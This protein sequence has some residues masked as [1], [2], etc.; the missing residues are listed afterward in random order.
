MKLKIPK[1]RLKKIE[2][3]PKPILE[4]KQPEGIKRKVQE[5]TQKGRDWLANLRKKT[6]EAPSE[7]LEEVATP[8]EGLVIKV[9]TSPG[10]DE[11]LESANKEASISPKNDIIK[12]NEKGKYI[13]T[14]ED[15]EVVYRDTREEH[16]FKFSHQDFE[17]SDPGL[18][19][20][21]EASRSSSEM[22][23]GCMDRNGTI[24]W[25][26]DDQWLPNHLWRELASKPV[27]ALFQYL[28]G[29]NE[30][31][32]QST[33]GGA[34]NAIISFFDRSRLEGYNLKVHDMPNS[35]VIRFG[36]LRYLGERN[37]WNGDD[38]KFIRDADIPKQE[39]YEHVRPED[40]KSKIKN[41]YEGVR[42]RGKYLAIRT[43]GR[44]VEPVGLSSASLFAPNHTELFDARVGD[45]DKGALIY[46][47]DESAAILN[48]SEDARTFV[49]PK[50]N[51]P[52]PRDDQK[53][54]EFGD[55]VIYYRNSVEPVSLDQLHEQATKPSGDPQ[56]YSEI[57]LD[58]DNPN[59]KMV[60]VV[61]PYDVQGWSK[62]AYQHGVPEFLEIPEFSYELQKNKYRVTSKLSNL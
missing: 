20:E 35:A 59:C 36:E 62:I 23:E 55:R 48:F 53:V 54:L 42:S 19:S 8:P 3:P 11:T 41:I 51:A 14:R 25:K 7:V 56:Y 1:F 50:D 27:T 60:A 58:P 28:P 17:A 33:D 44:A 21:L 37:G 32:I 30:L 26:R 24:S 18:T 9:M 22:I 47:I 16:T 10:V 49:F 34:V 12:N 29:G 46:E 39:G 15:F 38:S 43:V 61:N 52:S 13:V 45:F 2:A 5:W 6:D 4:I 57:L 31:D 40:V